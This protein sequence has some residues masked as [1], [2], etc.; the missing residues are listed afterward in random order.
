MLH[1]H[2]HTKCKIRYFLLSLTGIKN[3]HKIKGLTYLRVFKDYT[4]EPN[5]F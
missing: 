4:S 5:K 2:T 3:I 1:T